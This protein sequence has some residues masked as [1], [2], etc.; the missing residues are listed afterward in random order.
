MISGFDTLNIAPIIDS[1]RTLE[2]LGINSKPAIYSFSKSSESV[3]LSNLKSVDIIEITDVES[4]TD[5][6]FARMSGAI[7]T[8]TLP[9]NGPKNTCIIKITDFFAKKSFDKL[10]LSGN[11][12]SMKEVANIAVDLARN[13]DPYI[14]SKYAEIFS[15][16]GEVIG[17]NSKDKIVL[18]TDV[19]EYSV[20]D[21]DLNIIYTTTVYPGPGQDPI[22]EEHLILIKDYESAEDKIDVLEVH[23]AAG[24]GQIVVE[25]FSIAEELEKQ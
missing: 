15:G 4:P 19:D 18:T 12:Y 13:D 17:A 14:A 16:E 20:I 6:T 21:G 1:P 9:G 10:I 25:T 23:K 3:T 5:L 8:I 7:L 22:I 2:D 24:P 11:Q